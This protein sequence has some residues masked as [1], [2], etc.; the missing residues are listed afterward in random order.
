MERAFLNLV[1]DDHSSLTIGTNN[2][3]LLMIKLFSDEKKSCY[4]F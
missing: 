3:R 2:I 1:E 4:E